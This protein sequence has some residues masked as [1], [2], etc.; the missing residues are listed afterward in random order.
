VS[1]WTFLK[2]ALTPGSPPFLAATVLAVWFVR[3]RYPDRPRLGQACLLAVAVFYVLISSPI[4]ARAVGDRLVPPSVN[5]SEQAGPIDSIITLD[6]DN[7]RGRLAETLRLWRTG[8]PSKVI[9]LGGTWLVDGLRAGGMPHTLIQQNAGPGTTREQMAWVE[10][11]GSSNPHAR[12]V[13]IA[14][15]LQAP[16]VR[17]LMKMAGLPATLVA[18]PV[19]VEP[20]R[21]GIRL[22]VPSYTA[23]RVTRDALYE[24]AAYAYYQYRGWIP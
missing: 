23:L 17:G 19:D 9:V 12:V 14:S 20:P 10:R 5:A 16:R 18:A 13:L 4:V 6:G 7:R 11:Y 22:A 2:Q 21:S 3:R 8:H 24:H 1:P 15:R